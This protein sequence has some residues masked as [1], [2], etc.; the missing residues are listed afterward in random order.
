MKIKIIKFI[1]VSFF[2]IVI[3]SSFIQQKEEK[4]KI[5]IENLVGAYGGDEETENAY[6]GIYEDSIYYPDSDIWAKYR[7][8]GDTIVITN[9]DNSVEKLL[10]LKLTT[11]SLI[12]NNLNYDIEN[13][14]N[15]R[16]H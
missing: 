1:I 13:H 9:N 11:D 5:T 6:W 16:K 3:L 8:K 15:R 14:L 10:I 4:L 7:L 2:T 12:V